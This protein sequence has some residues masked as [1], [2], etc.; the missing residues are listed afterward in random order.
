M[1]FTHIVTTGKMKLFYSIIFILSGL[2]WNGTSQVEYLCFSHGDFKV[3]KLPQ[4]HKYLPQH[5]SYYGNS[6]ATFQ[7]DL[8]ILAGDVNPNPGPPNEDTS[9]NPR[10]TSSS[11]R[12]SYTNDE[13]RQL[14]C[15]PK[16][17]RCTLNPSVLDYIQSHSKPRR[18][19]RGKKGGRR[20]KRRND[21]D[22]PV[23]LLNSRSVRA[24]KNKSPNPKTTQRPSLID[25]INFCVLNCRS[26]RNKTVEFV[27]LLNEHKLDLIALTESWI[28][29]EDTS[30]IGNITPPGYSFLHVPRPGCKQ[31]GGVAL[32]YK[33]GLKVNICN[34]DINAA[35]FE[36]LTVNIVSGSTSLCLEIIYRPQ[37]KSTGCPFSIFLDEFTDLLNNH[38]LTTAPLLITGDFNIHV[39]IPTDPETIAFN[40]VIAGS[41]IQQHVTVPTHIDGNTL[42]L[43]ITRDSDPKIFSNLQVFDGLSDH[44]VIKCKLHLKRPPAAKKSVTTRNLKSINV[45]S[46]CSDIV[47]SG[48]LESVTNRHHVNDQA[49]VY[50]NTLSGILD[51][52]APSKTRIIT[53]R[54][55]TSWYNA[56][57]RNGKQIRRQLEKKWRK[58][59]LEIDRQ[60]F[61]QQKQKVI[62]LI[63]R[64]KRNHYSDLFT[65]HAKN[66]KQVFQ[67][68]NK[69][70][71]RNQVSPLP[72][73][74]S[75]DHLANQF[76]DFFTEK[77]KK[78]RDGFTLVDDWSCEPLKTHHQ[79]T[80][81]AN[82][83]EEEIGKILSDS[84][85]KSCELDP[86]PT[87]LLKKCA[88][89]LVPVITVIV[90]TS[91]NS[92]IFPDILKT[93]H[94]RPLLKKA[95]LD[96]N[97]FKNYRPVSNLA[98]L[99]KTIERV[100][101]SRLQPFI[102]QHDL[103]E[104]N[105]SAYRP[106]HSTETAL[107][108]VQSDMLQ[109]MDNGKITLL[110]LLDLSAAFDTIDHDK[111]LACLK[112]S[113]GVDEKALGWFRSY[114][115]SR[116]QAVCINSAISDAAPLFFGLPQG[117]CIGP[118]LFPIF[119]KPLG[120]I[121]RKHNL[122]YHLYA[123][124]TQI[125]TSINPTQADAD[126]A[127]LKIER[128]IDEIRQW[129]NANFLKLNDS[130]TE[131]IIVG[132]NVQISKVS[133]PP[134]KIGSA[135]ITPSV[136]VRNLGVFLDSGLTMEKQ[137]STISR[138]VCASIRNIGRVRRYL[139]NDAAKTIVNALVVPRIDSC[140]SLLFGVSD[141][142]LTRLQKLQNMAARLITLTKRS[143]HITPILEELHWLPVAQRIVFKYCLLVHKITHGK[144]PAYLNNVVQPYIPKR[145]LR[146]SQQA[147]LS[148]MRARTNWGNR[149]FE[150]AAPTI[151]N[152]LPF[153]IRMNSTIDKFKKDLKTHLFVS[154][155]NV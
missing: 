81:F 53:L 151:W 138:A 147:L 33:S 65:A 28:K 29:P 102:Q 135:D 13:L 127:V 136:H 92:G 128:C 78:I 116:S 67:L 113:I 79:L 31:G 126:I 77:I 41:G 20:R 49:R 48:L 133:I 30:V 104:I 18:T 154:V 5:I 118:A 11:T 132:N 17:S 7:I 75:D 122:S 72:E 137:V 69:L 149:A 85:T 27:H 95:N 26:V 42:D 90:N 106:F 91:L 129:M 51:S 74:V 15:V 14:N 52:H 103:N 109:A 108:K 58:S 142:Q 4:H 37:K 55:D 152:N 130:K 39:N 34:S 110:I 12:I 47:K 87:S 64:A 23:C 46:F 105:Q 125:Y 84:P 101:L 57:I 96:S 143:D 38:L 76:S 71:H 88:G 19:H 111:M 66:Q 107:L 94:I 22:A 153:N 98:F 68:A 93:A 73:S 100:V 62:A 21:H 117:S 50:S 115:N 123:D 124:D 10:S 140:N 99:G 61:C 63:K 40:K 44:H 141:L 83:T 150:M 120:N 80:T 24:G 36:S 121:L 2:T 60:L 114:F 25:N 9:D 144:A 56:D 131:F 32:V 70:L 8:L 145:I 112:N 119:T 1:E 82:V 59:R 155:F 16:V 134:V 45:D 6:S 148:P 89:V 43:F 86:I 139:T 146:S 35:S 97:V 54:P 3:N